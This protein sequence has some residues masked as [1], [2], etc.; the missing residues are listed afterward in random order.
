MAQAAAFQE[1]LR[2]VQESADQGLARLR[3]MEKLLFSAQ[4]VKFLDI[5]KREAEAFRAKL[6]K[7]VTSSVE[8]LHG[9]VDASIQRLADA[10]AK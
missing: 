10:N 6:E 7:D 1:A 4:S 8:E 5:R 3:G 9:L 2:K